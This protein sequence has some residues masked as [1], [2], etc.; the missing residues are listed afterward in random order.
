MPP[1]THSKHN[2]KGFTTGKKYEK[3]IYLLIIF[4][5]FPLLNLKVGQFT[6]YKICSAKKFKF[7][8]V[9]VLNESLKE[10]KSPISLFKSAPIFELP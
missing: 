10:I 5:F 4:P 2:T 9:V 3:K 8:S 1:Y 6:F 7:A